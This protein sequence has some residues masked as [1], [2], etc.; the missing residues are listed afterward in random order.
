MLELAHVCTSNLVGG[1]VVW[2]ICKR[3]PSKVVSPPTTGMHAC[4]RHIRHVQFVVHLLV[5][6]AG[7]PLRQFLQGAQAVI[8]IDALPVHAVIWLCHCALY[9]CQQ[10][11]WQGA[12]DSAQLA[13]LSPSCNFRRVTLIHL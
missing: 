6:P 1:N 3:H 13:R 7:H 2:H 4:D 5:A 9:C 8:I 12:M 10:N 11:C